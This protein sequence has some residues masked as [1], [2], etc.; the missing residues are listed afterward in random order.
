MTEFDYA[1]RAAEVEA[2]RR[3]IH[4]AFLQEATEKSIT[5]WKGAIS[6]FN[7][8]LE[9]AFPP[10]FWEQ[11]NRLRRISRYYAVHCGVSLRERPLTKGDEAALE[12]AIE[13]LEADPMFFRSGYVKAD[14]LRLVKRM[15]LSEERAERL[16]AVVLGVVDQRASQE[17]QRYCRLAR[18]IATPSLRQDLKKRIDGDDPAT[19]RR[20]RWM[21]AA[22]E[23]VFTSPAPSARAGSAP[24]RRRPPPAP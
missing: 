13:F 5:A 1:G 7:A 24:K 11:I 16:R 6:D 21:L 8:A 10:R 17:F 3:K 9:A 18:R 20:A 23:P 15:P 19:A 14:V 4:E 2:A 22:I 12:T